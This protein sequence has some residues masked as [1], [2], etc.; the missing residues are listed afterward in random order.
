MI[1]PSRMDSGN[2]ATASPSGSLFSKQRGLTKSNTM[3]ATANRS[4]GPGSTSVGRRSTIGYESKSSSNE[5]TNAIGG[6]VDT[7]P[8]YVSIFFAAYLF[9]SMNIFQ[10]C[11]TQRY[12]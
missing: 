2:A 5:K 7:T 11:T 9:C 4:L 10:T 8:A 6:A 1:F 3:A 12:L